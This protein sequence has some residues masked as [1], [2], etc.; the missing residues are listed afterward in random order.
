VNTVDNLKRELNYYTEEIKRLT[1]EN[2]SLI[3]KVTQ[4]KF[5]VSGLT[6]EYSF[7]QTRFQNL[8]RL[9]LG[10]QHRMTQGYQNLRVVINNLSNHC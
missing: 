10:K 9:F 6:A 3:G 7:Y 8:K 2:G 1:S 5:D 4:L